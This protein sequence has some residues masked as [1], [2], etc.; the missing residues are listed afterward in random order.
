MNSLVCDCKEPFSYGL[1]W[2]LLYV[3]VMNSFKCEYNELF[4]TLTVM[5]SWLCDYN[6]LFCTYD[7]NELFCIWLQWT[8]LYVT[9]NDLLN[10]MIMNSFVYD[11]NELFCMWL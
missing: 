9:V 6:E 7:C 4:S 11:C 2:T 8:L 5:N 3:S 10:V 1:E